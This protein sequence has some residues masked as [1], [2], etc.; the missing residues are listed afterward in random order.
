MSR[1]LLVASV[2]AL[3]ALPATAC[4]SDDSGA[5]RRV[6]AVTQTN[7]GCTPAAID[8]AAGEKVTFEVKNDGSKDTEMEGIEGTKLEEVLVPSGRT[9]NIKYDVPKA[10]GVQ[11][12][13]C[14]QPGGNSTIIQ[15]QVK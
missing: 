6:I 11:K 7:D 13:K 8:V 9:R 3:L 4:G 5:T 14:Y 1:T 15:L 10:T 12:V 2:L